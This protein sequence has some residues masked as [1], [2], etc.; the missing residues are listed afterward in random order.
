[1]ITPKGRGRYQL[2]GPRRAAPG[3]AARQMRGREADSD[4]ECA[5]VRVYRYT[6]ARTRVESDGD[7]R[8]G[9]SEGVRG[10][11][12]GSSTA[13]MCCAASGG[14]YLRLRPRRECSQSQTNLDSRF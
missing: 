13:A 9:L 1:M 4:R 5:L 11:A 3:R 6:R 7:A 2:F 8:G 12:I 14:L 10:A